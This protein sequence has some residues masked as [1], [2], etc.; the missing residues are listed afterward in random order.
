MSE[1]DLGFASSNPIKERNPVSPGRVQT[2]FFQSQTAAEGG[3]AFRS[4]NNVVGRLL[5]TKSMVREEF[6]RELAFYQTCPT[7]CPDPGKNQNLLS[8]R[9]LQRLSRGVGYSLKRVPSGRSS[10]EKFNWILRQTAGKFLIVTFTDL[11]VHARDGHDL[12][13]RNHHHWIAVSIEENLVIDSLARTLGPQP[14]S[15]QTLNRS[16]R[17][18]V[19]RIYSVELWPK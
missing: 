13:A 14:L 17:D 15:E 8:V 11:S 19:L 18:G 4:F 7:N 12:E 2:R 1:L 9:V 3:C 5:I 16:V 6:R 10:P